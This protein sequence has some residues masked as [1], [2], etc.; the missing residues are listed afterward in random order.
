MLDY[1]HKLNGFDVVYLNPYKTSSS[2]SKCG[3][4]IAPM[5]KACPTCGL[6]RDMNACLNLLRMW[7]SSGS[8]ESFSVSVMKLGCQGV[9]A[10]A[11]NPAELREEA[12]GFKPY[13]P[14]N[15]LFIIY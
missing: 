5:E 11:V 7:G 4:K 13:E 2:C 9:H 14:V 8:P 10:D 15:S 12:H 1:K 6:N 3:G